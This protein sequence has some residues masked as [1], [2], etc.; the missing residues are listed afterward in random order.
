MLLLVATTHSCLDVLTTV[1]ALQVVLLL[2]QEMQE[3]LAEAVILSHAEG[4]GK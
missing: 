2:V 3:M 1:E 4:V